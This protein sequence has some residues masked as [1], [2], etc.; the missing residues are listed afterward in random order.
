M[1]VKPTLVK[2]CVAKPL[3]KPTLLWINNIKYNFVWA[4]GRLSPHLFKNYVADM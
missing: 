4:T 3:T 2:N 1:K